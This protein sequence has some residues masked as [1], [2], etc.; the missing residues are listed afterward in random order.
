[1]INGKAPSFGALRDTSQCRLC[2]K[3]KKIIVINLD[4]RHKAVEVIKEQMAKEGETPLLYCM[5]GDATDD[6][7]NYEKAI[8]LSKGKSARAYRSLGGYYY[9]RKDYE[10]TVEYLGKS[11]QLN[12]FQLKTMLRHGYSAMQLEKWNEAA[13]SYRT[14]CVHCSDVSYTYFIVTVC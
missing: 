6:P 7:L 12:S 11:L 3:Q 13:Q 2:Y 10:K 14:Y 9:E 4:S 1:M 5:L 8:E